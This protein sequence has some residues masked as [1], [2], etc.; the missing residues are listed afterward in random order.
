MASFSASDMM[1]YGIV[2]A[3][4][5]WIALGGWIIVTQ[6]GLG[7]WFALLGYCAASFLFVVCAGAGMFIGSA[8]HVYVWPQTDSASLILSGAGAGMAVWAY[9]L[10]RKLAKIFT[11]SA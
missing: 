2:A 5:G 4:V 3:L 10:W 9:L 6:P 7:M 1:A 8:L 11:P